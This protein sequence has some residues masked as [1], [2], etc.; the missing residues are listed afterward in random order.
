MPRTYL[1]LGI[2][3]PTDEKLLGRSVVERYLWVCL[4][5][6]AKR[7]QYESGNP[8]IRG[9]TARILAGRFNLG[10]AKQV[11]KGLDYFSTTK[12]YPML[13]ID[14]DGAIQIRRFIDWQGEFNRE[15]HYEKLQAGKRKGYVYFARAVTTGMIKIGF[16]SNPWARISE[17]Q[18]G[19]ADV[20]ELASVV[21]GTR[22]DEAALHER[23]KP[24]RV[25]REWF[26][27]APELVEHVRRSKSP[28]ATDRSE[29]VATTP[30]LA[31]AV[32][33]AVASETEKKSALIS[34]TQGN[35]QIACEQLDSSGLSDTKKNEFLKA[36]KR[37]DGPAAIAA[38]APEKPLRKAQEAGE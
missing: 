10:T 12:P 11:Q 8:T 36:V 9:Q 1:Y 28:V 37:G 32:A 20:L 3:T 19:S 33:V 18:T 4:L 7:A 21:P 14:E 29:S 6:L 13:T 27:P 31:V 35:S 24:H 23:F 2:D 16:S 17:L 26:S 5:C 22:E 38:L 25:N 15:E 34:N 30:P